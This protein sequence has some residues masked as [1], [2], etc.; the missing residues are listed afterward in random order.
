MKRIGILLISLTLSSH[1]LFGKQVSEGDSISSQRSDDQADV[2]RFANQITG[3]PGLPGLPAS[4]QPE[5]GTSRPNQHGINALHQDFN[6]QSTAHRQATPLVAAHPTRVIP[7]NTGRIGQGT[8]PT[9]FASSSVGS[10]SRN[11]STSVGVSSSR[12]RDI[13]TTL[14]NTH[15]DARF[16]GEA[17]ERTLRER[18]QIHQQFVAQHQEPTNQ[19]NAEQSA[20]RTDG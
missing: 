2:Q 17:R 19:S 4:L 13:Y 3:I 20:E 5:T 11:A 8:L 12:D 15:T 1:C 10:S 6:R 16:I 9:P 7:L 18:A 14:R